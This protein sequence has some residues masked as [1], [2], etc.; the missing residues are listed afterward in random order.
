MVG[1]MKPI[2]GRLS[3]TNQ[4]DIVVPAGPPQ[5][6][7]GVAQNLMPGVRVLAAETQPP[8][9]ALALLAAHAL[10]CILKVYLSR[11]G[12]DAEFK[13][14]DVYHDLKALWEMAFKQGLCVPELAPCWVDCLSILHNRPYYLRYSTGVHGIILPR[15]EP[16]TSELTE[17]LE[18]VRKQLKFGFNGNDTEDSED[19]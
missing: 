7:F 12:S 9:Y 4:P 2:V 17:L 14:P 5:T 16:M 1:K 3:V 11:D 6:Y 8:I 10:E 15:A 18:V 19:R 13:K